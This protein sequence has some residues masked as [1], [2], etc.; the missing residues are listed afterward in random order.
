MAKCRRRPERERDTG[1][2]RRVASAVLFLGLVATALPAP[3]PAPA[4]EPGADSSRVSR[5]GEYSGYTGAR[6]DDWV[7]RSR[8]IEVRDGTR[9]AADILR[10]A[11]DGEPVDEPLPVVWTYHRYH[12][13]DVREDGSVRTVAA[14]PIPKALLRHGYV[15]AAVDAR[16]AGASFGTAR[17]L[18]APQEARDTYDV[19]EWLADRPW[20]NG[21]IGMFGGSYL[22]ITQLLAAGQAPPH[23]EAVVPEKVLFDLYRSLRPG[24]VLASDLMG[25]WSRLTRTLDTKRPAAPVQGDSGRALLERA[26]ERHR[27]NLN[28]HDLYGSLPYRDGQSRELAWPWLTGSP[29]T[30]ARKARESDVAVYLMGGWF[31][32]LARGTALWYRNLDAPRR[33]VM[34]PWFHQTRRELD[35]PAE[36]L[37]W[38][39]RWLKG[40]ENG[41]TRE[42]PV[43]YY[44]LGAAGD[45]GWRS[46]A[47]WP[48]PEA[49]EDTFYLA[50]GPSGTIESVHDGS[51]RFGRPDSAR[52]GAAVDSG[53]FD[54]SASTGK[55]SRWSNLYGDGGRGVS[56]PD[57]TDNDRKGF[58]YTTPPLER[59]RTVAGHPVVRLWVES[60]A[61]DGDFFVYLEEVGEDGSSRYLT[62]GV[63]RASNRATA[64]PPY[65]AAGLPWHR[66]YRRD[67]DPMPDGEPAL[68]EIPLQPVANRFEEGERIRVTVTGA[69]TANF[70]GAIRPEEPPLIGIHRG[71]RHPSSVIL[72]FLGGR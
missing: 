2:G 3:E 1:A 63:L 8:Y 40:V 7:R 25:S 67:A 31:D 56:Y 52:D 35:V 43:R 66:A 26:L 72:P 5:P 15:V 18:F 14:Q 33:L 32:G 64:A 55:P 69:D 30:W 12:R 42:D 53:R 24:G 29:H 50:S 21:K 28:V 45:E 11:V 61:R 62:E 34:G 23:L 19:T 13:A 51:L 44:V 49:R 48:P 39:D 71:S 38:F 17:G 60:T 59:D 20:S 10:P 58:T 37:R 16:G 54:Y 41:V 9:L 27:D 46:A 22:G 6:Y 36:T 65:D 68:L 47:D 4:Q 70:G 57:M